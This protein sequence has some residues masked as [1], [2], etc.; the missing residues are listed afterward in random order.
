[1][2]TRVCLRDRNDSSGKTVMFCE[3]SKVGLVLLNKEVVAAPQRSQ[4]RQT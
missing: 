1:M 3:I 4:Q 2:M